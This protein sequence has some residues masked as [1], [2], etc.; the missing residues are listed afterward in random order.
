M[1]HLV[2]PIA[3]LLA[4]TAADKRTTADERRRQDLSV[5]GRRVVHRIK[6]QWKHR[7]TAS[8]SRK[9][10]GMS[11]VT[12]FCF[13]STPLRI[14]Q[15][16]DRLRPRLFVEIGLSSDWGAEFLRLIRLL[17]PDNHDPALLYEQVSHWFERQRLL[18]QELHILH[19]LPRDGPDA[20]SATFHAVTNAMQCPPLCVNGRT[21]FLWSA[22]HNDKKEFAEATERLSNLVE[23]AIGRVKSELLESPQTDF[24]VFHVG[25]WHKTESMS[26][27]ELH[28]FHA[29]TRLRLRRMC[30][31]AEERSVEQA[32]QQYFQ[33]MPILHDTYKLRLREETKVPDNRELWALVFDEDFPRKANAAGNLQQLRS[34]AF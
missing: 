29:C 11:H 30:K 26:A 17:E 16:L 28:T 8:D 6:G 3:L 18:F 27:D 33:V 12:H 34:L 14:L 21:F 2:V 4:V 15:T 10:Q 22:A 24:Q 19:E 25:R 13:L 9:T 1:C 31:L 23:A 32:L 5:M 7:L 20:Q